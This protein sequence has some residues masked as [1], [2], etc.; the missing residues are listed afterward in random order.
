MFLLIEFCLI[1]SFFAQ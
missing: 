1:I